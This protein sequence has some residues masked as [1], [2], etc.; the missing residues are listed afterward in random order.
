MLLT[1]EELTELSAHKQ[2]KARIAWLQSNGIPFLVGAFG[3][4]RV[5]RTAIKTVKAP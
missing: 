3:F 1:R 5:L 4:P 2:P